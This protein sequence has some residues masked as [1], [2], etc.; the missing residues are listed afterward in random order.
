MSGRIRSLQR[1]GGRRAPGKGTRNFGDVHYA[2]SKRSS[3]AHLG[4][5]SGETGEA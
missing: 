3:G 2:E 4:R 5:D 1:T